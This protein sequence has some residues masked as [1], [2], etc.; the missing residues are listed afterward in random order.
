MNRE[1][2]TN[3]NVLNQYTPHPPLPL[4]GGGLACLPVGRGGGD[5]IL[6]VTFV[7]TNN[8]N[9]SFGRIHMREVN[10]VRNSSGALNPVRDLS[11][12][13]I[14]PALRGGTPYGAEPG[15]ILKPNPAAE[16]RG[17]I[18]NGVNID[19][20]G[21]EN[22]GLAA[23]STF[24]G[25]AVFLFSFAFY[26]FT[27]APTVIW[28]DNAGDAL[29][30]IKMHLTV[31]ADSHPLFIILGHLF[32]YLPF[33][34]AYSLNLLSAVTSSLAV[35]IVYLI[36]REMTGS[37]ASAII[38]AITLCVSHAF[39]LHAVIGR[40]YGLNAFFVTVLVLI[41]LKWR[42]EPTN[43]RFLYLAAFL[44]GL[45]LCNH[46][47]MAFTFIGFLFLILMTNPRMLSKL[48]V[49]LITV[50]SFL[51]GS[52]LLIYLYYQNLMKGRTASMLINITTGYHY[53]KN[54]V[55]ISHGL[56][57]DISMYFSYLFYQFPVIGFSLIFIGIVALFRK[58]RIVAIFLLLLIGVNAF[59]FLSF[60]PGTE[61]TTKYTF[62]I[63]DYAVF[64]ILI[65]YGSMTF[66]N[67]LKNKGYS[68]IKL[69]SIGMALIILLPLLLYN[70]TPYA[71]KSL[72]I[73]LLH[74]R[75]LPYRDNETYF[76]NPSKRG[77][78]G[79]AR[80]AEEAL[81][82]A[83]LDSIIIADFTPYTVLKYFQQVRG[84]R[85]DISVIDSGDNRENTT[86][87]VVS[88]YYGKRDIYLAS[89]EKGYYKIGRLKNEYDFVPEGVL[90]KVVRKFQ[91]L[92]R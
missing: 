66:I 57:R 65:G 55:V 46:I 87:K 79:A 23:R 51:A 56:F 80:Y 78:T 39:W 73:D 27:L 41:L 75:T 38:G 72:E 1:I 3:T 44:F 28:G 9:D 42:K 83:S 59:F 22:N 62:Y 61:R 19:S 29:T 82:T 54:M 48:K 34:P 58:D 68:L 17:I 63:S 30:A 10:P 81:N 33:E 52:S 21:L 69:S 71:S 37:M 60:G 13:G 91:N 18:S 36:V 43:N 2:N 74:A 70:I 8:A 7:L 47:V 84:I 20:P 14:N 76:L 25:I 5:V 45:G 89:M 67:Y 11:L 88:N 92:V 50:C 77:Y 86:Q 6:F 49:L 90:Y 35:L 64:S 85:N 4:K 15:I 26:V 16:Q 31:S 24:V 40:I 32:S 12:N 53:K